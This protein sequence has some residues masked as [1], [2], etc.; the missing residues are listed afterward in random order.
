[1]TWDEINTFIQQVLNYTI[2]Q[3]KETPVTVISILIFL[4]FIS[5][6]IFLAISVRKALNRK[7]LRHFK[8]DE[9]TSY[10]L[11]RI[12]QYTIITIGALISFQ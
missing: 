10:T 2:F 9:G 3:I 5:G 11:S 7:I 1:M 8:I 12:T 4:L 6:F